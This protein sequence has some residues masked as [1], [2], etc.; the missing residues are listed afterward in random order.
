METQGFGVLGPPKKG[1]PARGFGR[2]GECETD[3]EP[4]GLQV[5]PSA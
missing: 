3:G 1:R 2:G 5:R 4:A